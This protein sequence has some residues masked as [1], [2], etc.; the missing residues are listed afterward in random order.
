MGTSNVAASATDVTLLASNASR[1]SCEFYND[2]GATLYILCSNA[3]SS[4]TVFTA[5]VPPGALFEP[6]FGYTGVLKGIWTSA[7]GGFA[8]VTENT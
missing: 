3:T 6:P 1:K 7:D 8:R 2:S 5:I 4:A